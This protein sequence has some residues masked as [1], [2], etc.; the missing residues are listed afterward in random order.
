MACVDNCPGRALKAEW[1][2]DKALIYHNMAKCA[3]CGLCWR[4][5]PENAIEFGDLLQ[6]HWDEVERFDIVT[7][8]RCS[9]TICTTKQLQEIRNTVEFGSELLCD[10]CRPL[11]MSEKLRKSWGETKKAISFQGAGK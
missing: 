4:I 2:G 6:G 3:R 1:E 10:E 8:E 11:A 5:C 9:K 7:C